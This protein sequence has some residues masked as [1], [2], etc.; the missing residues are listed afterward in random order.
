MRLRGEQ[1][2]TCLLS[3]VPGRSITAMGLSDF[4]VGT[5]PYSFCG[6]IS[7]EKLVAEF[8]VAKWPQARL[9]VAGHSRVGQNPRLDSGIAL[10]SFTP[11]LGYEFISWS[12]PSLSSTL[13]S[14]VLLKEALEWEMKSGEMVVQSPA[15]TF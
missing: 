11:L 6:C 1:R 8:K 5:D 15:P 2:Y 4:L 13:F 9:T 12:C 14:K 10:S 7:P 3:C